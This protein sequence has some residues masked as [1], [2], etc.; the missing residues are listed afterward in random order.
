MAGVNISA[1]GS[2]CY[3]AVSG[4]MNSK[5]FSPVREEFGTALL[6]S[7]QPPSPSSLSSLGY[8]VSTFGIFSES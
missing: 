1:K 7:S 3:E 4:C 6:K 2:Y 5:A 8:F